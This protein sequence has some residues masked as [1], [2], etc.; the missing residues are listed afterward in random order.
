MLLRASLTLLITL[1]ACSDSGSN[2]PDAAKPVDAIPA[3][4]IEEMCPATVPL[5]VDVPDGSLS[6]KFTPATPQI[7]IGGIVKFTTHLEHNV[8]PNLTMSDPGLVVDFNKTKCLR[9]TH[10]GTFSFHCGPHSFVGTITV[11]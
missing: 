7:S 10:S 9:F 3:T 11:Q 1:A 4:V 2:S 5:T 6:Y 8:V